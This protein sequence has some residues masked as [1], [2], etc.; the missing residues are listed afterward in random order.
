[1]KL[2]DELL[3]GLPTDSGTT[4]EM[5]FGHEYEDEA[6]RRLAEVLGEQEMTVPAF[7]P[8]PELSLV[9]CSPD[10]LIGDNAGAEIKCR[11]SAA[12]TRLLVE[13][14]V[15]IRNDDRA[16]VPKDNVAQ[17]QFSL[18]VTQR[19]L[20][21]YVSFNPA[22]DDSTDLL[23][24][25][26]ER[27]EPMIKKLASRAEIMRECL[28]NAYKQFTGSDTFRMDEAR[29]ERLAK[30]V[31]WKPFEKLSLLHKDQGE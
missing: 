3:T 10:A 23:V 27:D 6:R 19:E 26:V 18:W 24:L 30:W 14:L 16:E 2:L 22:H 1:L 25:T 8:H 21:Y 13:D 12:H 29:Q 20:W 15:A 7:V 5:Q 31:T 11:C 4:W 28:L 9:G 17:V